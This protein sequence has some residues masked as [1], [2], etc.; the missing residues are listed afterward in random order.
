VGLVLP[1]HLDPILDPFYELTVGTL[2]INLYANMPVVS[3]IR[4]I[5]K[6]ARKGAVRLYSRG[7]GA[8]QSASQMSQSSI[9][10]RPSQ[11]L[12][13]RGGLTGQTILPDRYTA[14]LENSIHF[15]VTAGQ[16]SNSYGSYMSVQV[17]TIYQP[18]NTTYT[19]TAG[20]NLYDMRGNLVQGS[21]NLEN[22]I[23][24]STFATLYEKYKVLK[25]KIRVNARPSATG[26]AIQMVLF[27]L[28]NDQIP[29]ASTGNVNLALME[30]QP[31][32][33]SK[34]LNAHSSAFENSLE[35]SQAMEDCL[36]KRKSQWSSLDGTNMGGFPSTD[37][38]AYVGLYLQQ[39]NGAA[40][41]GPICVSVRLW[42]Q[43]EFTDLL[44]QIN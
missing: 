8:S 11:A 13:L 23:G 6:S 9:L 41:T 2:T 36:G 32:A 34:Q 24:Y 26:D 25:Y 17:G 43:V 31:M 28:G 35:L 40:N 42:Q 10:F 27:P 33:K 14:W 20:T 3:K 44:P 39:I 16:S 22:P 7:Y 30:G 15:Y 5:R 21:S 29:S 4:R 37:I 19:A 18:F 38:Q 12:S 1:H